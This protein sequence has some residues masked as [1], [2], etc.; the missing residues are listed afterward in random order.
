MLWGLLIYPKINPQKTQ[1]VKKTIDANLNDKRA[2]SVIFI[3]YID[4][5][6]SITK[7]TFGGERE[8][9]TRDK[10]APVPPFQGGDL[11]RSSSSPNVLQ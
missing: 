7:P 9:R 2:V 1:A 4:A 10:V 6:W 8:I 5:L 3:I 11:N